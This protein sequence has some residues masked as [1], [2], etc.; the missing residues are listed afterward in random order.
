MVVDTSA[1]VA[2]LFGE[3]EEEVFLRILFRAGGTCRVSAAAVLETLIV[4][5]RR[6]RVAAD[7]ALDGLLYRTNV[8][9]E[10]VTLE[11]LS[12]ARD[13]YRRFGQG[14]GGG[15]LNFG[16]CFSYALAKTNNEPLLY[17]GD[18]FAKTDIEAV[19]WSLPPTR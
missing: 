16:N 10:P 5:Q 1:L 7:K 11:Q 18:D 6:F 4:A 13:G 9:I 12:A 14:T 3:P 8:G 17:K 2:V 15:V 19:P